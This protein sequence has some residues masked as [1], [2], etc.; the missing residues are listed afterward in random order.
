MTLHR[1][2]FERRTSGATSADAAA[3]SAEEEDEDE[4]Q[5]SAALRFGLAVRAVA[6]FPSAWHSPQ[7]HE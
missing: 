7:R 4:V 3:V 1:G 5:E 2:E 6:P